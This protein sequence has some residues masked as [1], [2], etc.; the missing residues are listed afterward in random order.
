MLYLDNLRAA[1]ITGVVLVHLSIT[2]GFDA[3]WMYYE[4]GETNPVF[5]AVALML[6]GI[7]MAF[8]LGLLFLIAGYFTPPAFDRKGSRGFIVDRLKR[9]AIPWLFYAIFLNPLVHYAVDV[10]GI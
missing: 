6:A 1:L 5:N 10:S 9:L 8:A 7:G 4:G 2:Y 3:D